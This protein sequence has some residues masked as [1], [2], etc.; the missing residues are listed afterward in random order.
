M[1]YPPPWYFS[2]IL[3]LY[4]AFLAY[5]SPPPFFCLL[6]LCILVMLGRQHLEMGP[7][8]L[9]ADGTPATNEPVEVPTDGYWTIVDVVSGRRASTH[10]TT[11]GGSSTAGRSARGGSSAGGRSGRGVSIGAGAST[12]RPSPA[13]RALSA[14]PSAPRGQ[15][16]RE[17]STLSGHR[18][19][20]SA[21]EGTSAGAVGTAA[22][23][24]WSAQ[25]D[26]VV[27][28]TVSEPVEIVDEE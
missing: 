27:D 21:I 17:G 18:R 9:A 15:T 13:V 7:L 14:A 5:I 11:K 16:T 4:L 1:Q 8:G 20:R 12:S 3:F 22:N 26:Q 2:F 23:C 6:I 19:S 24:L 10:R 25:A 28:S